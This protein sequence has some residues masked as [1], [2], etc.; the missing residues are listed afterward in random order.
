MWIPLMQSRPKF[1]KFALLPTEIRLM[2]WNFARP[3]ERVIKLSASKKQ[4]HGCPYPP[5]V[6]RIPVPAI[7]HACSESRHV[8][9]Q[10][11]RI[12]FRPVC[13]Y[14]GTCFDTE[15]D[16][17]YYGP[18]ERKLL[19][20]AASPSLMFGWANK[21]RDWAED[22]KCVRNIVVHYTDFQ[23]RFIVTTLLNLAKWCNDYAKEVL[24]LGPCS[25]AVEEGTLLSDMS[26]DPDSFDGVWYRHRG[27]LDGFLQQ[28]L[29]YMKQHL[30][31]SWQHFKPKN[32]VCVSLFATDNQNQ[33]F[34]FYRG[35]EYERYDFRFQPE[36]S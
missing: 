18:E 30:P 35:L 17:I 11:Y 12:L 19:V 31:L 36:S 23:E 24:Y 5:L 3:E 2:I 20:G 22:R 32:L 27:S 29:K 34:G 14:G 25:P 28:S 7:L 26:Q 13:G 33:N 1:T 4:A 6:S 8:A 15:R 16:F 21:T 9:L 10:W